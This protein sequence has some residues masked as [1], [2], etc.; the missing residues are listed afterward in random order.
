MLPALP[1]DIDDRYTIVAEIGHGAHAIVYR[2]IDRTLDREVAVKLLRSE[3]VGSDIGARFKR[4][5]RLTSRLE[6]P[7]I[8][9]VYGTGDFMGAPYFVI[10]LARGQSLAERLSRE[11]QLPIHD[12]LAITRQVASAL[13][14]AHRAGVV[15]RDVKPANVLL[16]EDGALLTDFGVARV[17]D[18]SPGTVVTST[19][20]A[21]GTLLYMS[22]EQLC[23]E[24]EIDARS[25][26]Y[27]LALML[28]EMLAGVPPHVAANAEGLRALRIAA[29]HV[30]V[31]TLRGSVPDVVDA[32]LLRALASSPAD[33]FNSVM[34]FVASFDGATQTVSAQHDI[35]RGVSDGRVALATRSR[36]AAGLTVIGSVALLSAGAIYLRTADTAL[37]DA[38]APDMMSTLRFRVA[39]VGDTL[40]AAPVARALNDELNAWP[41]VVSQVSS[42][43]SAAD[44]PLEIRVSRVGPVTQVMVRLPGLGRSA[45]PTSARSVS[46]TF[47]S[48]APPDADSLRV[49]A[50]RVVMA[51][52]VAPDSVELPVYVAERATL[53]VRRYAQ[54]WRALLGGE[55]ASAEQAFSEASR[56]ASLPQA[57]LWRTLV[58]S[59]RRPR[60]PAVWRDAAQAAVDQSA[61]L[62]TRDSL[63]AYALLD[64]ATDRMVESCD[65]FTRAT[66]IRGGSFAA[67]YGLAD[68]LQ[69]DSIIVADAASPTGMRF[70][71]SYW[72]ALRAFG[73]SIS[74]LPSAS[75]VSLY[76]RLPRVTLALNP[77]R[78]SGMMQGGLDDYAG[79]PSLAGDSVV[80]FPMLSSKMA[81][82]GKTVIPSTYQA[83][84]RRGRARL[85]Q[86]S[87]ALSAQAPSSLDAQLAHA[88]A[89]ESSGLLLSSESASSALGVLRGAGQLARTRSDSLRLGVA[90]VGVLL[91]LG[92]FEG[93]HAVATRLLRYAPVALAD[94]A[95]QLISIAI[96]VNQSAVAESL[97]TRRD[98]VSHDRP[99]GIPAPVA[100]ALAKY[101]VAA[102]NGQCATLADLRAAALTALASHFSRAELAG[103][104]EQWLSRSDWMRVTCVGA[105][106]PDGAPAND[107]VLRGFSALARGD[108][109]RVVEALGVLAAARDAAAGGAITWDT[110]FAEIS[111]LVASRDTTSA[112]ARISAALNELESSMDFV[113][114][115]VAQGAGLRRTLA[116]CAQLEW[117]T[118][119]S[120]KR[121]QCRTALSSLTGK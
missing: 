1:C 11:R 42:S 105:P 41:D 10:E 20:V 24:D 25:D 103:T 36:A 90:E 62:S 50:A 85:L 48:A 57:A 27:A 54:G 32:A 110:R 106:L 19:G 28:Y 97:L 114:F 34:E 72:G 23:A 39:V 18:G 116:I 51:G 55:L 88:R 94:E 78:R 8:A 53:A 86:L 112:R 93:V 5:I 7:N 4:E 108:T 47:S 60:T 15:H 101:E 68:C 117:P 70:R 64:R 29:Q 99:D 120:G 56:T 109:A 2:A 17:F 80:V 118:E 40:L 107:P 73:E 13:G 74:R 83:A 59:W 6:H 76:D 67:W 96:L 3:L 89:L 79:L 66:R 82:G 44:A 12:A 22:P 84:I 38:A 49:L 95:D 81:A 91:R 45:A 63:L 75:L 52:E 35:Q 121:E 37:T 104:T 115:D 14:H 9:H 46:T 21:V 26:Q 102:A 31:R 61:R 113:L 33:R 98:R 43:A 16:T 69:A 87:G 77:S 58:A 100:A 65:A 92:D 111:L 30:P 119:L 71:T